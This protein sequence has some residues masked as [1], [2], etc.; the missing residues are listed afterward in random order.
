M[1]VSPS[2]LLQRLDVL[3]RWQQTQEQRLLHR[4]QQ[5]LDNIETAACPPRLEL[6]DNHVN[7]PDNAEKIQLTKSPTI[8]I[9]EQCVV[10]PQRVTAID[11]SN[12][13][14][15]Y[16][17]KREGLRKYG[18]RPEDSSKPVDRRLNFF[19]GSAHKRLEQNYKQY[20]SE[21][22]VVLRVEIPPLKLPSQ[23]LKIE[24][25]QGQK[26]SV[27]GN[28]ALRKDFLDRL[29][30]DAEQPGEQTLYEQALENE[31]LIFEALERKVNE[32]AS[33]SSTNSDVM[34][35]LASSS[36]PNKNRIAQNQI[37]V[38][39]N[40]K[41]A[42]LV[43]NSSEE[44]NLDSELLKSGDESADS[45][46]GV[47]SSID[48]VQDSELNSEIDET[49]CEDVSR[50]VW[51][52]N[53]IILVRQNAAVQTDL[54]ETENNEKEAQQELEK[55]VLFKQLKQTQ[56]QLIESEETLQ[57]KEADLESLQHKF[58]IEKLKIERYIKDFQQQESKIS[59][60]QLSRKE[61][62]DISA[63]KLQIEQLKETI[64]LK[65]T[66]YGMA[67]A[68]LR[69]QIK[70]LEK[71]NGEL[72]EE[73]A[74]I[75]KQNARLEAHNKMKERHQLGK[76]AHSDYDNQTKLLHEINRNL[77]KF[78][79]ENN[80]ALPEKVSAHSRTNSKT[81]LKNKQPNFQCGDSSDESRDNRARNKT[82]KKCTGLPKQ[83]DSKK[84]ET[85]Q[86][87]QSDSEEL[88]DT[89]EE[90]LVENE[91][92]IERAYVETFGLFDNKQ[93]RSRNNSTKSTSNCTS[94]Q[95]TVSTNQSSPPRAR[96]RAKSSN[97]EERVLLL[98]N[99]QREVHTKEHMRREYPDGTVKYL[100]PDGVQETRYANG[101]IRIKDAEG[102]LLL[103]SF[104]E[105]T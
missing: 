15:P 6:R 95:S 58:T 2:S 59:Q 9:V 88:S 89:S 66:R 42:E 103:D 21:E 92:V 53:R 8:A 57:Q 52:P 28:F 55:N 45:S 62:E 29:Y 31:L 16:L 82:P 60:Q 25:L 5:Q 69:N 34:L 94:P 18:I 40:K 79:A 71:E 101:R 12:V 99:G 47:I 76:K 48:N 4:H 54:E 23:D 102:S 7:I 97:S 49:V 86:K 39:S 63:L 11:R 104:Q 14:K 35:L 96:N 91:D 3:K 61:R 81:P 93:S 65:D 75:R 83:P 24:H 22:N 50:K 33:F 20:L 38:I 37:E 56:L 80:L 43:K 51:T 27:E 98:G 10:A 17:R 105:I 78:T 87:E 30:K 85:N 67:Q 72:Q 77:T 74:T 100:Y 36:T 32:N 68:R 41:I 44:Q 1:S 26:T 90:D 46:V 13:K 64:K 19:K 70:C 84:I 73:V